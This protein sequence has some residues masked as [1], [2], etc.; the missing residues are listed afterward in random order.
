MEYDPAPESPA[1]AHLQERYGLFIDGAFTDPAASETFAS[2]NP[3]NEQVLAYV[4]QA[5]TADVDAAVTAARRAYETTWSKT[6]RS[7][8][9]EVPL[10]HRAAHSGALARTGRRGDPRQRKAHPRVT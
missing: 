4:T 1:I 8:T 3:A 5:S 2:V 7:A 9:L 6:T 10:S